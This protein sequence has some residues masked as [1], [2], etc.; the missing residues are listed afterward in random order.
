MTTTTTNNIHVCESCG[1]PTI[2][3]PVED[4]DNYE[5]SNKGEVRNINTNRILK[6]RTRRGYP[7]VD[8]KDENGNSKTFYVHALVCIAF[9]GPRPEGHFVCHYPDPTKSNNH[10]D[11]LEWGTPQKNMQDWKEHGA[12]RSSRKNITE[13]QVIEMREMFRS[14]NWSQDK[15]AEFFGVHQTT[16]NKIMT[17]ARRAG[18]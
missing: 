12:I 9:H 14:G 8:L 16:V 18:V 6:P 11:N 3:L 7:A 4:F 15:I 13:A 5:V 2:W 10:A 17:G 1:S